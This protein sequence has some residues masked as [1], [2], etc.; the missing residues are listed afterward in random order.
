MRR[1]VRKDQ[2]SREQSFVEGGLKIRSSFV[3][4]S[5]R[6]RRNVGSDTSEQPDM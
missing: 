5:E 1:G 4:H 6:R 2:A 3:K